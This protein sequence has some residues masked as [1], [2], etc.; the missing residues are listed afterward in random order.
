MT[1][2]TL[3]T[4]SHFLSIDIE[5]DGL[6]PALH[7]LRSIGA[8]AIPALGL[9]PQVKAVFECTIKPAADRRPDPATVMWWEQTAP[10]EWAR[11]QEASPQILPKF[12]L[13]RLETWL[14]GLFSMYPNSVVL[15]LHPEFDVAWLNAVGRRITG[16]EVIP[17]SMPV[18]DLATLRSV[19]PEGPRVPPERPHHALSDAIA[20][21]YEAHRLLRALCKELSSA[22]DFDLVPNELLECVSKRFALGNGKYGGSLWEQRLTDSR[23]LTERTDHAIRHLLNYAYQQNNG[24]DSPEDNLAA[25]GWA[26]AVLLR[27]E[28]MKRGGKGVSS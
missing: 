16:S 9:N 10:A 17:H 11:L 7:S 21:G 12:G 28:R 1:K 27:A 24:E 19:C 15:A 3:K 23:W 8:A 14:S 4:V 25:V 26:V 6:D 2:P 13:R 22:S 5:T 18:W 20:Q